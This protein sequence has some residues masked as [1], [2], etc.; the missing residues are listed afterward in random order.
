MRIWLP[1]QA[2]AT[3]ITYTRMG[4]AHMCLTAVMD[5]ATRTIVGWGLSDT[6]DPAPATAVFEAA[7][8]RHCVPSIANSDQGSTFTAA[9][10]VN[11]LASH[12]VRRSMDVKAR[13]VDNVVTKRWLRTL[14][15]GWLRLREH[16]TPRELRD[17]IALRRHIQQQAAPPVAGLQ[18]ATGVPLRA[19]RAGG[20]INVESA[21]MPATSWRMRTRV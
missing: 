7:V 6:P 2:W 16:E 10:F 11:T 18:D 20:V 9:C 1:N 4:R 5:R 21:S 14:K 8:E 15:S 17:A 12:D 3:D 19:V 13:W